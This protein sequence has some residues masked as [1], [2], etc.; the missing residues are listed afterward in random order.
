MRRLLASPFSLFGIIL[1]SIGLLIRFGID[2][3][4]AIIGEFRDT[5]KKYK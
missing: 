2:D 3:E 4:T 5:I 1:L